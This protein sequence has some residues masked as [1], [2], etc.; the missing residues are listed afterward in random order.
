MKNREK[1]RGRVIL[2]SNEIGTTGEANKSG[3]GGGMGWE[4]GA[5]RGGKLGGDN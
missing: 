5:G 2:L 1:E 3:G 4:K